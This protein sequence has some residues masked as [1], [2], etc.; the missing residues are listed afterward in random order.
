[1]CMLFQ[2][3]HEIA[4]FIE[5]AV[6]RGVLMFLDLAFQFLSHCI[7]VFCVMMTFGLFLTANQFLRITA[8]V[9]LVSFD[10]AC[11]LAP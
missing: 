7:A 11:G 9:M 10:S 1:M 3:T 4:L 8:V 5:T 2:L 6:F